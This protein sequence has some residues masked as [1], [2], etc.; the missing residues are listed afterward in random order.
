[1]RSLKGYRSYS[2]AVPYFLHN[3]PKKFITHCIT[4][5]PPAVQQIP[6]DNITQ[7]N[8]W[9]FNIQSVDSENVY[10]LN[11][12]T[13]ECSCKDWEKH[14]FPCKHM[15]AVI[16]NFPGITWDELPSQ[17]KDYPAFN[18][19]PEIVQYSDTKVNISHQTE[20]VEEA[21]GESKKQLN[22]KFTAP[23]RR[24]SKTSIFQCLDALKE[25]ESLIYNIGNENASKTLPKLKDLLLEVKGMVPMEEGLP[26][27]SP[28]KKVLKKRVLS[29]KKANP[30]SGN[31]P[32]N[33]NLVFIHSLF[34]LHTYTG[35]ALIKTKFCP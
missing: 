30:K 14:H 3:R 34:L 26:L 4:R 7:G 19:D 33:N 15:L 29:K 8:N 27:R 31:L 20:D 16:T 9:E 25:M 11:L 13:P 12:K 24:H 17:F 23:G 22:T 10:F 2:E 21:A 6:E 28:S 1:M 32:N 18:I 5:L 35:V